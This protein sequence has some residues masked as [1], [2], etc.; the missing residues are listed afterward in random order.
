M[1]M[2][3]ERIN[4]ISIIIFAVLL[5]FFTYTFTNNFNT[6]NK[7]FLIGMFI[8]TLF[9]GIVL[10]C[11]FN[12]GKHDLYKTAFVVILIFGLCSVFLTP[13][14][15]V[16]DEYEHLARAEIVS[17]GEISTHY[18]DSLGFKSIE[19]IDELGNE[20]NHNLFNTNLWNSKINYS[21]YYSDCA[22]AQNPFY[23]YLAP[24]F[25]ILLAKVLDLSTIWMLYLGR[26]ANLL[27]YASVV[28]IAIK[29]SPV[30]KGPLLIASIIPLAIFQA[31]SVSSDCFFNAFAI[32]SIAYFFVLYKSDSIRYKDLGIFY[33]S[34]VLCGLLKQPY[35]ALSL[36]IFIVPR[37][38]FKDKKQEIISKTAIL[39]V[40][41]I[42][43]VWSSY[44]TS[45]LKY[46]WRE[47]HF[48]QYHVNSSQQLDFMLSNPEF[49]VYY[50][51]NVLSQVPE[52]FI[53][54]FEFSVSEYSYTSQI[55]ADFY[56]AYIIIISLF[57]PLKES[58]AKMKR[59]KIAVVT[60]VVYYGIFLVQYLTWIPVKSIYVNLGVSGRYFIP[61]LIFLPLIFNV[62][63]KV[64]VDK[65]MFVK[66]AFSVAVSFICGMLMLTT[67][68]KF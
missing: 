48:I 41:V 24:A 39:A 49:D 28:S 16:S 59:L 1:L 37:T 60:A 10:I 33:T 6:S 21:Q 57:Y 66:L 42:G 7:G 15:D 13:I 61:L 64:N 5:S 58:L 47:N 3:V 45:Q 23:A 19:S 25:G 26:I 53:R 52:I 68:A 55:M 22:F 62:S 63:S 34:I 32:L 12:L 29:K 35:L 38:N 4:Y 8:L 67:A 9:L 51:F 11:Y 56:F 65:K 54:F 44:A 2:K 50:I 18:I 17:N 31:G 30:F 27:L 43:V 14:N 20:S 40:L 46:S 36:L